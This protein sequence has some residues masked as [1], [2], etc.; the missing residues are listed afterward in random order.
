MA[1]LQ[2]IVSLL[3]DGRL[4]HNV[5]RNAVMLLGAAIEA[6]GLEHVI[7]DGTAGG[8]QRDVLRCVTDPHT[9]VYLG[10]RYYDLGLVH[11]D[12]TGDV[13]RNL[14]EVLDRPVFAMIQ[15][16]PFT[17]FMW[18][19][20]HGASPTTHFIAPTP[21]FQA[22]AQ[23][24]NPGLRHFHTVAA[25]A[26]EPDVPPGMLRPLAERPVDIFMCCSFNNTTP[27]LEQLRDYHTGAASPMVRLIDEVY[28]TGLTERDGSVLALFLESYQRHFGQPLVLARPWSKADRETMLVLSCV[29]LR[30]RLTRRF[31]AVAGLSRLDP[32]LRILIT[33]P[34]ETRDLLPALRDCPNVEL[35][36]AV[37][38]ARARQLFLNA[39]FALNVTPTYT[40]CVTERVSN[41]MSLG[42]C[43]ISDRNSYLA[44]RFAEG[45]EILFME[46]CDPGALSPYFREDLD[47][48]QAIATNGRAKAISDFAPARLADDLIAVMRQAL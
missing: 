14:F 44:Q 28:Q 37:A 2:R 25:V 39:K 19:R 27:S 10:H 4:N 48:A 22:E 11:S 18:A 40:T 42:C 26:T 43:V 9:G 3:P 13:R 30:I 33:L 5:M 38:A 15:D 23:F 45:R 17:R 7:L 12:S 32:A 36:G 46:D 47:Q 21:E 16:H 24:I 29:D 8:F 1:E 34:P 6:R 20:I 41:A 31:K 35:I